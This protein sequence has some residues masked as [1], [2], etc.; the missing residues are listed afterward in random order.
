MG[1]YLKI[2]QWFMPGLPAGGLALTRQG[3]HMCN[4]CQFLHHF[5]C[6]V[7]HQSW[8]KGYSQLLIIGFTHFSSVC[9][10]WYLTRMFICKYVQWTNYTKH[11][12]T[13]QFTCGK[14]CCLSQ[15]SDHQNNT[16]RLSNQQACTSTMIHR[17]FALRSGSYKLTPLLN[18]E[19]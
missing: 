2:M 11:Y 6:I 14:T 9:G 19:Q 18:S 4:I 5:S 1:G 3:S 16:L 7:I 10:R 15:F 13:N 12:V 8:M 17:I